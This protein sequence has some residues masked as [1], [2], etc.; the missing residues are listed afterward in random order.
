[1]TV[2]KKTAAII[3]IVTIG[4]SIFVGSAFALRTEPNDPFTQII[5]ILQGVQNTVNIIKT[6]TDT[7]SNE[8]FYSYSGRANVISTHAN[9]NSIAF[10]SANKTALF[11]VSYQVDWGESTSDQVWAW[12][13][14]NSTDQMH[15]GGSKVLNTIRSDDT[16]AFETHT[17]TFAAQ[18]V[19]LNVWSPSGASTVTWSITVQCSS[20]TAVS[21]TVT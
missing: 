1:M 2:N 12:I 9:Y 21:G 15:Y 4:L 19:S 13:Y 20:D 5:Q 3:L 18:R 7:A 10:A 6:N 16:V 11:T 14:L 17:L 8:Q